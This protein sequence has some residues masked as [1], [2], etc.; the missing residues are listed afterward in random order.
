MSLK[1]FDQL[2]GLHVPQLGFLGPSDGEGALPAERDRSDGL[3]LVAVLVV[4]EQDVFL[5][6]VLQVPQLGSAVEWAGHHDPIGDCDGG[7]QLRVAQVGV[8]AGAV[9]TP[10][11]R[12]AVGGQDE[13]AVLLDG[14]ADHGLLVLHGFEQAAGFGF[15]QAR[16]AVHRASHEVLCVLR[17]SYW[18]DFAC[19][20]ALSSY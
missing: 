11:V 18:C 8:Q 9:G 19:V 10:L 20:A 2:P 5:Q 12:G 7:D 13:V 16:G 1:C 6:V 4:V 17:R 3:Q 14:H 15:P